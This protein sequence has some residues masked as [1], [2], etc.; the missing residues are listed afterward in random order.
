M[1]RRMI[2]ATFGSTFGFFACGD[3]GF[4]CT[5]LRT[6]ASGLSP[7]NGSAPVKSS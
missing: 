2:A 1:Q 5:C 6:T 7:S 4:S 3:G